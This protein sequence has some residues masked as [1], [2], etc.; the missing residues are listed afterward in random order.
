MEE[1]H[2]APLRRGGNGS[3]GNTV[4]AKEGKRRAKKK[5]KKKQKQ[6]KVCSLRSSCFAYNFPLAA[7]PCSFNSLLSWLPDGLSVT[8]FH[9]QSSQEEVLR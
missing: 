5:K 1:L 3:S 6:K 8:L 4:E 2:A 9:T 7:T